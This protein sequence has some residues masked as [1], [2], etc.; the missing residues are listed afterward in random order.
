MLHFIVICILDIIYDCNIC[1]EETLYNDVLLCIISN[2]M[3]GDVTLGTWSRLWK[4]AN[5]HIRVW[6]IVLFI[7]ET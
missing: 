4:S 1:K 3:F 2:L 7:I 6:F 5:A